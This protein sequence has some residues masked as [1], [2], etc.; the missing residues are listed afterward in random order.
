MVALYQRT[1]RTV[2]RQATT[3]LKAVSVV[4]NRL[5]VGKLA[6]AIGLD[7]HGYRR[8]WIAA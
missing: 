4:G 8:V 6:E 3:A 5:T 2:R 1:L 7:D